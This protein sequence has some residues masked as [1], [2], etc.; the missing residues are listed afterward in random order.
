MP[1]A[2]CHR[3]LFWKRL[4]S[5]PREPDC[6]CWGEYERDASITGKICGVSDQL[7][8]C[9][10]L[11]ISL[12]ALGALGP[13]AEFPQDRVGI[14][15]LIA[16]LAKGRLSEARHFAYEERGALPYYGGDSATW[17][18]PAG[19]GSLRIRR[20]SERDLSFVAIV[21]HP[22]GSIDEFE[23]I[24]AFGVP[25]SEL[26]DQ[27][28]ADR[29]SDNEIDL[30]AHRKNRL[31]FDDGHHQGQEAASILLLRV[32]LRLLGEARLR[33][34]FGSEAK[35]SS[36]AA[37]LADEI[38]CGVPSPDPRRAAVEVDLL[39]LDRVFLCAPFEGGITYWSLKLDGTLFDG[40]TAGSAR[41]VKADRQD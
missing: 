13:A 3:S 33:G 6:R 32:A 21:L 35:L 20:E 28:Q 19:D 30:P 36:R 22:D 31:S 12:R 14:E 2:A 9:L 1:S 4:E 10:V 11:E 26:T 8:R 7:A 27:A 38:T 41:S 15:A 5:H 40:G 17:L 37:T 18:M 34:D 24:K 29:D 39:R 25:A 23:D 16:K